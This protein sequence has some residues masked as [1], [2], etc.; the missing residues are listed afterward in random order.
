MNESA[1]IAVSYVLGHFQ[2]LGIAEPVAKEKGIHLH[3]PAGAVR[4]DGPSAGVTM[5]T[6]LV[7]LLSGRGVR[8]EI[9]MTGEITLTGQVLAVG[10]IRDKVLAAKRAGIREVILPADN[11]KDVDEIRPELR[12]GMT[13]DFVEKYPDLLALAFRGAGRREPAKRERRGPTKR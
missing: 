10:G 7:S 2:E 4:K 12:R 3:V 8:P 5:V 1:R 11:R 9:A 6:A 13:F